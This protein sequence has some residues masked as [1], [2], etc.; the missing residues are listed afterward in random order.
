MCG[1]DLLSLRFPLDE[2]TLR[3]AEDAATKYVY[4][5]WN[6]DSA[7]TAD[8]SQSGGAAASDSSR[9]APAGGVSSVNGAT[10]AEY[11]AQGSRELWSNMSDGIAEA[12]AETVPGAGGL[13]R[14][15]SDSG[16]STP[17]AAALLPRRCPISSVGSGGASASCGNVLT[18]N[19]S[20]ISAEAASAVPAAAAASSEVVPVGLAAPT[21]ID[22]PATP[23]S[24]SPRVIEGEGTPAGASPSAR[25]TTSGGISR[26]WANI[27]SKEEN[28]LLTSAPWPGPGALTGSAE[29]E[30]KVRKDTIIDYLRHRLRVRESES[31]PGNTEEPPELP[32]ELKKFADVFG[33]GVSNTAKA[34]YVK[35]GMRNDANNCYVNVVI[36]S[37]LPCSALMQLLSF[38]ATSD[39]DRP[40]YTGMVRLCKEFHGKKDAD[41]L[42]VLQ[43]SQV[44][45]IISQWQRLG[46]QQ[47]AGEFLFYMLNG[48]HE[49]CKWKTVR[50]EPLTTSGGDASGEGSDDQVR[51]AGA[52]EDSPVMRIFGG[53]I[54]SSVRSKSAKA[55]SVSLEPF[56]HLILD[57]SCERVDSVW[58]ALD[59][60]CRTEAVNDGQATK[61]LQF[62]VLPK[63]LV[64]NLKRFSYNKNTECPQKI[65]KH[66]RYEDKLV[67]DRSWLADDVVPLEY[68]LTAVISHLGESANGGHYNAAVRYN[69]DWFMYDDSVVRQMEL[70][71]VMSQQY[72]AY[73][74]LYCAP[75]KVDI[76][77]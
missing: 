13:A 49:E 9:E 67:F 66:V 30:S 21:L 20:A 5:P 46:A 42:N 36:Q 58:T 35:R 7:K 52:Q 51:S 54:R 3:E 77:P 1:Q 29:G 74:L 11:M 19:G 31:Q 64:V 6:S 8:V 37:L 71:E 48:M 68:Q 15:G 22:P 4:G 61:A 76:Q 43:L 33:S 41:T 2:Q 38:C 70:R 60:Y 47:D 73:L 44:K 17:V 45:D 23:K 16:R 25:S 40:F 53:L 27:V 63:V 10:P 59:A 56:N 34:R 32:A 50:A 12:A 39:P 14:A 18:A 69:N 57:I 26:T 75:G 65:K 24:A 72:T 62:M 55:D 28:P